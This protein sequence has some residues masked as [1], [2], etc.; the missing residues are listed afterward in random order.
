LRISANNAN[1]IA[2]IISAAVHPAVL[3]FLFLLFPLPKGEN[4]ILFI[5]LLG[6]FLPV[7]FAGIYFLKSGISDLFLIPARKR[8]IPFL[9]GMV[10]LL[11][12][13]Y[14]VEN[15]EETGLHQKIILLLVLNGISCLITLFYK[16]SL[17]LLS[18]SFLLGYFLFSGNMIW[19]V[20]FFVL[21][22]IITFARKNLKAHSNSELISGGVVGFL[23]AILYL[24]FF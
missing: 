20:V 2:K 23:L 17:H 24:Y 12:L 14:I 5:F 18:A 11:I 16:I 22:P 3:Q 21:I 7:G 4:D 1:L 8:I 15:N 6:F 19:G 10:S 13:F 9:L